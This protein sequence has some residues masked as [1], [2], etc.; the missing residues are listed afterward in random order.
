MTENVESILTFW[1]GATGDDA[2]IAQRQSSQWWSKK[3]EVDESIRSRFEPLLQQALRGELNDW[4]DT[5]RGQLAFILLT[6]Q[7]P[8]NMYRD[9]PASFS[10][11]C[12]ALA[13]SKEG[14]ARGKYKH[15]QP[16]ERV[17]FFMPLEHSESLADQDQAL[18]LFTELA[19][20]VEAGARSVFEGFV[21]FAQWHRKIIERFGRFPH[22]NRILGRESSLEEYAFLAEPGSSF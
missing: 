8:R 18:M 19:S 9:T 7:F 16:I 1:F 14:I 22:R 20:S 21:D 10:A 4:A 3:A 11:D 12:L 6:D 15:L 13:W 2:T 5:P 17:F